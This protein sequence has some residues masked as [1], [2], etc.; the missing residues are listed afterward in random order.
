MSVARVDVDRTADV[1]LEQA[2]RSFT[3]AGTPGS[4]VDEALGQRDAEITQC[5]RLAVHLVGE[6]LQRQG[7]ILQDAHLG[8]GSRTDQGRI[9][10]RDNAL[11]RVAGGDPPG[12]HPGCCH[13]ERDGPPPGRRE[14]EPGVGEDQGHPGQRQARQTHR[15]G[16]PHA[17]GHAAERPRGAAGVE[18]VRQRADRGPE[19]QQEHQDDGRRR[20]PRPPGRR[21]DERPDP[22]LPREDSPRRDDDP[23]QLGRRGSPAEQCHGGGRH[24]DDGD[25]ERRECPD[26]KER[27]DPTATGTTALRNDVIH[28][29]RPQPGVGQ[30]GRSRGHRTDEHGGSGAVVEGL[31]PRA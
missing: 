12:R 14:E 5:L 10:D 3:G 2:D 22:D 7:E 4:A 21:T 19:E 6:V 15:H 26:R 16:R 24:G 13:A 29:R 23:E 8:M 25:G 31:L 17:I 27:L 11:A 28:R 18:E 1:V 9:G 30:A 20:G